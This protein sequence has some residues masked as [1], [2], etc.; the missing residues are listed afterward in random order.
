M[1]NIK[2]FISKNLAVFLSLA[3]MVTTLLPVLGG[4]VGATSYDAAAVAELK[5]AWAD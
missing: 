5:A 2:K 1:K 4:V 3:I